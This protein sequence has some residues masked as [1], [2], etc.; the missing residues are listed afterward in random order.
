MKKSTWPANLTV[1]TLDE[2]EVTDFAAARNRLLKKVTT[3]W[4]LFL[5]R[6]ETL[7]DELES[8]IQQ[9]C[10]QGK[11]TYPAYRL[12]RRTWFL[13]RELRRGETGSATFVRLARRGWGEWQRP[14]HEVWVGE[15]QVGSLPGY[16][17]HESSPLTEMITKIN[18]YSELDAQYRSV[19]GSRATFFHI[20]V[21]PLG[22]FI[23]NY[24][25]RLGFLDGIPGVIFAFLMSFHSYLTWTKLY[26]LSHPAHRP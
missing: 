19:Q 21:Y 13:G 12:A 26:L 3:D 20:A 15:G 1:I 5:D 9:V 25:L 16:I 18:T 14:V 24:L 22:K 2:P 17:R 11:K 6:D 23:Q 7:S 4:V 10:S 8:A